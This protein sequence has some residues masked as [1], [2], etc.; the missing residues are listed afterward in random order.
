ML[1]ATGPGSSLSRGVDF[2]CAMQRDPP[3]AQCAGTHRRKLTHWQHSQL[4]EPVTLA[5][6]PTRSPACRRTGCAAAAGADG[7]CEAHE[8]RQASLRAGAGTTVTPLHGRRTPIAGLLD[9]LAEVVLAR[10]A[11]WRRLAACR[12]QTAVMFPARQG[13]RPHVAGPALALCASCPVVVPCRAAG[14]LESAG[15]WGGLVAGAPPA[16]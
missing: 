2:L 7:L 11:P 16:A 12:G 10:Q 1:F 13:D 15:V 5:E 9:E 4:G 8:A 3:P 14:R 6:R